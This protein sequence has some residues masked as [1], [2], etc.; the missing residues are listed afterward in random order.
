METQTAKNK[1]REVE[2][3]IVKLLGN[4]EKTTGCSITEVRY[5]NDNVHVSGALPKPWMMVHIKM[6]L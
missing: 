6:E 4:L 1:K 3:E 5:S 2:A